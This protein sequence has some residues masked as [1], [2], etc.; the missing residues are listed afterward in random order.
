MVTAWVLSICQ[1]S[2]IKWNAL[3]IK[4]VL[5]TT[6]KTEGALVNSGA[7]ENFLDPRVMVKLQLP[8]EELES[9]RNILN[10]DRTNNKAG[11]ITHKSRHNV[12]LGKSSQE[13]DFFIT[14]LEQDRIVLGYPFLRMF[15]RT[16][17][18]S[19]SGINHLSQITITPTKLWKH[20]QCVWEKDKK[21]CIR[22]THFAQQWAAE[23]NQKRS[24]L[25]E[26]DIPQRY[27][28]H[29]KVFSEAEVERLPPTREEN[30]HITF[31]KGAPQ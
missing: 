12:K 2:T 10:I 20:C 11:Q 28:H 21:I 22:K 26:A 25:L 14:D 24:K 17:N 30:M 1:M 19:N 16:I 6:L 13:I 3:K 31:K 18:W 27:S 23:V 7:T 29:W 8:I 15:N 4:L 9:P 5:S